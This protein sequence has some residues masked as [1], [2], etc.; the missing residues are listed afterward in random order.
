MIQFW[1]R[2]MESEDTFL[3]KKKHVVF[4]ALVPESSST[5]SIEKWLNCIHLEDN[6]TAFR[7]RCCC[8]CRC[9]RWSCCY[10]VVEVLYSFSLLFDV[11][12]TTSK[13]QGNITRKINGVLQEKRHE[14]IM[15]HIATHTHNTHT[16]HTL[17]FFFWYNITFQFF[18]LR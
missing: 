2:N 7:R 15:P 10:N 13:S 17:L 18:A 11:I 14:Y 5:Y 12:T 1:H 16:S 6:D 3:V 8:C 4:V 9:R